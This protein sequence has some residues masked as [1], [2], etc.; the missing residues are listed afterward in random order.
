[1]CYQFVSQSFFLSSYGNVPTPV[2][3]E[4]TLCVTLACDSS[5]YDTSL[6]VIIT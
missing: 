2:I 4:L 3:E 6:C 5:L 1:M